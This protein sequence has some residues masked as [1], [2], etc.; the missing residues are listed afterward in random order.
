[1][2]K[3]T[4]HI[5]LMLRLRMVELYFQSSARPHDIV[6]NELNVRITLTFT[7]PLLIYQRLPAFWARECNNID[8]YEYMR[9]PA[10]EV[11]SLRSELGGNETSEI[12]AR[13]R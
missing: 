2:L 6:L 8:S 10:F 12:G 13:R 4:T 3:L 9:L 11:K 1:M 5:K 7:L